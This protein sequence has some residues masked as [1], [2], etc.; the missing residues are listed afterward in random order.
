MVIV[1]SFFLSSSE[2][3]RIS[4]RQNE[5]HQ[6]T[7]A[8]AHAALM[9]HNDICPLSELPVSQCDFMFYVYD[10]IKVTVCKK[11]V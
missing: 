8:G 4:N 10:L 7:S 1:T 6:N 9:M 3:M 11:S 5:V 2:N